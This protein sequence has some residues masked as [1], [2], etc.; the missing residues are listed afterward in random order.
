VT[1]T[2]QHAARYG[3]RMPDTAPDPR[4]EDPRHEQITRLTE[5]AEQHKQSWQ[6]AIAVRDQLLVQFAAEHRLTPG[7]VERLFDRQIRKSNVRRILDR[8]R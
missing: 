4:R 5:Q 8:G 1:E 2:V 7:D 3:S 6:A